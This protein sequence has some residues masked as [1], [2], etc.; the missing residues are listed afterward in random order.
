MVQWWKIALPAAIGL[1]FTGWMLYSEVDAESFS[2]IHYSLKMVLY[3]LLAFVFMAGR[4][5]GYMMRIRLF[6]R[7]ELSWRQAFRVIMLWEFTSAI[8]PTTVGGTSVA[9]VFVHKEGLSV[10]KSA[11]MV[12]LTAF[13]DELFFAIV[14]PLVIVMVGFSHLFSFPG[15]STLMP[16]IIAGYGVKLLLTLALSY[17]IFVNPR[18]F[19]RL[20]IGIFSLPGLRKWRRGAIQSA[21]DIEL[22]SKEI[23]HYKWH[24]WLKAF[25]ATA[26]SWC[27]RFL[28]A[29]AIF[30]A[31]VSIEDH[32]LVFARQLAMWVPMIISPTPGGAG[33][34]EY[35]F[36]N[37]LGDIVSGNSA[38]LTPVIALLWRGV[39]YYPYL[40]IGAIIIPRWVASLRKK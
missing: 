37:F 22:S 9:V 14:F 4:D 28:V 30:L 26:M 38:G 18:G 6:A 32:V 19:G 17:G 10:G 23:K 8:T 16:I 12:M 34:A 31:F 21:V 1:A 40:I 39:T 20:I 25:G 2:S 5:V 33:F 29:N 7:G 15:V 36:T 11:T 35:I 24:F 3:L 27:S 13:F